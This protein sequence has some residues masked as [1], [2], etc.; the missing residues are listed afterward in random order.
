MN[1]RRR[2]LAALILVLLGIAVTAAADPSAPR[3]ITLPEA[4]AMALR[5]NPALGFA[6][7]DA[8]AALAAVDRAQAEHKIQLRFD[9]RYTHLSEVPSMSAGPAGSVTL[10]DKDTWLMD[11]AAQKILYS[12]GRLEALVQQAASAARA[13]EAGRERTRQMVA[14]GAERAFRLLAAAQQERESAQKSLDAAADHL[15]MAQSRFEARAAARFDVIMAEVQ[16]AQAR[17]EVIRAGSGI[18]VTGAAFLQALGLPDGEFIAADATPP[19]GLRPLI[20]DL[21]AQ[22]ILQ[23]PELAAAGWQVEGA[24]AGVSAAKGER[25]P[26]VS[27]AADYQ[28]VEPES[29]TQYN[30]WAL[31][32][33]LTLPIL[34]GGRAGARIREAE[35]RT[36][37]A[38]AARESIRFQVEL[39]VR[40][41]L[42]R[43]VSADAQVEVA[44]KR[45]EQAEE[46]HRLAGVRYQAGV[47]TSTEIADAL[48]GLTSAR[49]GLTRALTEQGIGEADLRLAVGAPV[50]GGSIKSEENSR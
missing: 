1:D 20:E 42:A 8:A 5:N 35:E 33:I 29:V 36:A 16:V 26:V 41:A 44:R 25:W 45:I 10:G 30:R 46:L 3:T 24:R 40:Q 11:L 14:W 32:A 2:R 49:Q 17:Q 19:T 18:E 7:H 31:N 37:Q 38:L 50:P 39:E 27:V 12:G 28:Y 43:V 9:S 15:R 6:D 22:A 48:A 34:D 23:R 21:L 13:V 4:V 47:G